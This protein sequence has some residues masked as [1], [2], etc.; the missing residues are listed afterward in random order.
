MP[1]PS[2]GPAVAV[3][4]V[5][6]VVLVAVVLTRSLLRQRVALRAVRAELARAQ[7][8]ERESRAPRTDPVTGL[9]SGAG[10]SAVVQDACRGPERAAA[11]VAVLHLDLDGF[12]ALNRAHGRAAGDAVLVEVARRLRTAVRGAD[13]PARLGGD[14]FA[15][16]LADPDAAVDVAVR[17]L[18]VL[19][20]PYEVG[21]T[22][23]RVGVAVGVAHSRVAGAGLLRAA[24]AAVG[25]AKAAGGG[26]VRVWDEA[27]DRRHDRR[28][29][30]VERLRAAVHAPTGDNRLEVH[31]QP[32][33]DVDAA[34]VTGTECL[35]RW[36]R[37]GVVVPPDE[38]VPLAEE[39]G[40]VADLGL[41]VL[42]RA[43]A[44]APVL[45]EAAG[46]ALVVAV[47]VSASQL[48]DPRFLPAVERA[49][50]ALGEDR[51]VLEMTESVLVAEDEATTAALDAVVAAGAHLTVDDFGT[52]CATLAYLRRR[53]FSAFKVD[54]SY[55]RDLETDPRTR[56]L[57]EGLVLLAATMGM[58]LVVEGVETPGQAHL[59]R[60]MG[61]PTH[62][63]FRYARP[64]PVGEA[65][66]VVADLRD[67][68]GAAAR[69]GAADR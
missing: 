43:V 16:L 62:Q 24:E 44:E 3:V 11:P 27:A 30:T 36:V 54:R 46:R 65:A 49:V 37:D 15:V 69:G 21:A 39:H 9:L 41:V 53:P 32:T 10:F 1:A 58:G 57:V 59:L 34:V 40:L 47:N 26:C 17:L 23:V 18:A 66:R 5:V 2:S 4:L 35:V 56:A 8:R 61:A 22:R 25:A 51:L 60:R 63:G 50:R 12:R 42:E 13:E 20:E 38:F 64:A 55:V 67:R 29:R 52:G 19:S 14:E 48:H 45:H 7:R 31:H 68:L 33:V 6:L 28:V